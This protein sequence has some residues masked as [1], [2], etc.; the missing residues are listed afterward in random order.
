MDKKQTRYKLFT[1]KVNDEERQKI[2]T[3]ANALDR[4]ASDAVRQVVKWFA[5]I[6]ELEQTSDNDTCSW[7]QQR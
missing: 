3:L 6:T 1:F 4:S 2:D 5:T 7:R